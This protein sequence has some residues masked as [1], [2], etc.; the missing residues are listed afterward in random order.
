MKISNLVCGRFGNNFFQYLA[1]KVIQH[2]LNKEGLTYEYLFNT[3]LDNAYVVTDNNFFEV[4]ENI[5]LLKDKDVYLDGYFQFDTH[6]IKYKDYLNTVVNEFNNEK[7]NDKYTVSYVAKYIKT[8]KREYLGNEVILHLRLDDF[9]GDKVVLHFNDYIEVL[10]TVPSKSKITIIVDGVKQ[11]WE[12]EYI[13]QIYWF[14]QSNGL[15]ISVETDYDMFVDFCKLYYAPSFISSNSTYSY[16]AGLLG[17]HTKTWCPVN[18]IYSH[19][20][21]SKF[22]ENTLSFKVN[23]LL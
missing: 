22:D 3:K 18:T 21:I 14:C 23:Y 7:I 10:N 17:K 4:L 19:Q 2:L 16:L 6:I 15:N 1:S 5:L 12:V 11:R 20:K 13:N 8:F 9:I